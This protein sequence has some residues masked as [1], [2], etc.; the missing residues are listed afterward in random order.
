MIEADDR[1]HYSIGNSL[2]NLLGTVSPGLPRSHAYSD[3]VSAARYQGPSAISPKTPVDLGVPT[4]S[5]SGSQKSRKRFVLSFL[6]HPSFHFQ[7][8]SFLL[9]W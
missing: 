8:N 7:F 4:Q 6:I 1:D 3:V 9:F 5:T 2:Q